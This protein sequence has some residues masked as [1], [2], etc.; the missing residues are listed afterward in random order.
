MTEKIL[1]VVVSKKKM[2]ITNIKTIDFWH[3]RDIGMRL[4]L[5]VRGKNMP[6]EL[7]VVLKYELETDARRPFFEG[8]D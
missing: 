2:K 8:Q 5:D 3:S 1:P 7:C 4:L 6:I